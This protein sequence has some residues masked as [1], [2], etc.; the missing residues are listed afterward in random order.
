VTLAGQRK[1]LHDVPLHY[2][3]VAQALRGKSEDVPGPLHARVEV[4]VWFGE[5]GAPLYQFM[6]EWWAFLS[7]GVLLVT[8][9]HNDAPGVEL[10]LRDGLRVACIGG[11]RVIW[12]S[13]QQ[14]CD[15]YF[16]KELFKD[17]PLKKMHGSRDKL[18]A[19]QGTRRYRVE[20]RRACAVMRHFGIAV[21]DWERVKQV[22]HRHQNTQFK[23]L[24]I[25]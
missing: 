24:N 11:P 25:Y 8:V 17:T 1:T 18:G 14:L 7:R 4:L 3:R 12:R 21:V 13:N 22:L 19:R 2:F 23:L 5:T 6:R 10:C 20:E 16:N 9:A 15:V